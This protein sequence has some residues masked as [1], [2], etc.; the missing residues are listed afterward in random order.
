MTISYTQE[1][2]FPQLEDGGYNWGA[3]FN[4]IVELLDKGL[5][6]NFEAGENIGAGDCVAIKMAD[7]KIYK[8]LDT[9]STLT[10]TIGIAP[11]AITSGNRGKVRYFGW[12]DIDT[13]DTSVSW[14]PG[15]YAY[16]GSTAGKLS[17]TRQSWSNAVG[18]AK[19]WTD[20]DFTTRLVINPQHP[21]DARFE[22]IDIEK[23]AT[24]DEEVDNGE[25]GATATIDWTAGNIQGVT[26]TD[27]CT[28]TFTAP[29]G[30]ANLVLRLVQDGTGSHN[31]V[32]PA[33]VKWPAGTEP[34]W[35]ATAWGV[36]V[37]AFYCDGTNYYGSASLGMA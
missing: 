17:K 20:S 12:C 26:L 24:Y 33:T 29:A 11:S 30:P 3:V 8:A 6:L 4:G 31:P 36:D 25:S 32:W 22:S 35:T 15:E 14:S 37:V 5:E 9:D 21:V 2:L 23:Q 10:P 19:S 27:D 7:A 28:F 34:T 16:V 18:F 13:S 1:M